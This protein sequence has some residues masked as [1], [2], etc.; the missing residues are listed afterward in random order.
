MDG[1]EATKRIRPFESEKGLQGC[2]LSIRSGNCTES[3]M[4]ECLDRQGVIKADSFLKK[5]IS[6]EELMRVLGHH[7]IQNNEDK[8][9]RDKLQIEE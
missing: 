2:F 1:K 8:I 7:F 9:F 3:E 4:A 6:L 5:P